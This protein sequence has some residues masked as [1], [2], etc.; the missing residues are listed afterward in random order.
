[1]LQ[2]WSEKYRPQKLSEVINQ[3]HAV[4]RIKAFVEEKNIPH[5]LFA[6]P[7]GVGKTTVALALAHDLYGKEWRTNT[8]ELNASV[9]PDTPIM[10][11]KNG[12][13]RRINFGQLAKE[14]FKYK[15]EKVVKTEDLEILSLEDN[16]KIKFIPVS[17]I[18]RHKVDKIAKIKFEGGF[19]KTSLNH[20]VIIINEGGELVSKRVEDI[21][22]NDLLI[23]FKDVLEGSKKSLNLIEYRPQIFTKLKENLIVNSKIK[24]IYLNIKMNKEIAWLLGLYLAEGCSVLQNNTRGQ[25]V[26][27]LSSEE[28]R[29]GAKIQGILNKN[30]GLIST[31]ETAPSGFDRNN[32][33]SIQIR[34]NNT[35]LARFFKDN[36]YEEECKK[37]AKF[38]RVPDFVYNWSIDNRLNFLKGYMGD[39]TGDWKD[40]VRFSSRSKE[41]LIDI[42][43]L[44][45]ISSLE[46]SCFEREARIIWKKPTSFYALTNL[47]PFEPFAKLFEYLGIP[48][49]KYFL[50]HQLYGKKSKRISKKLLKKFFV[51]ALKSKMTLNQE[52]E[53]LFNNCSKL[54]NSP[55]S[56]VRIKDIEISNCYD[57]VYDVSVPGIE[58]FWG[59]TV[60]ILLHNSDSR[61]IDIIRGQ[62]KNF[63]RTR[64]M[65]DVGYRLVVLD[66]AD[67]LTAEAQQAL[68]R[69]ME[70][71]TSVSRFILICNW[72]SRII[73][74]I[75]SRA[76]IFRFKPL[77]EADQKKYIDRIVKE[78]KL[79]I[80]KKAIDAII[81]LAEGDLRK[82]SNLLQAS[83]VLGKKITEDTIY[84][85]ASQARPDDVKKMVEF[86]LEGRFEDARKILQDMLLRQGLSGEDIIRE[87]HRQI[88]DLKIDEKDK[89]KLIE[90]CGEYEYRLSQG[91]SDTIQLEALLAQ[92][93]VF[94]KK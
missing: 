60:P 67:A 46:T 49:A 45:R 24:Q 75:Q 4:E 68:R 44:G 22:P 48:K 2:V 25:I 5:M 21:K 81:Y 91:S 76:A 59:G 50:R 54:L 41:N 17:N 3:K 34:A 16:Y 70:N 72:S 86:T 58:M 7:A 27:T 20:S 80:D 61:G 19:I 93:L 73:E 82:I 36:F 63:A 35:Q 38:K 28:R 71:F 14:Y 92:F 9:T 85:V 6:G 55:L 31:L 42:A 30:F 87:I 15:K 43:W 32:F 29:M 53:E 79:K 56:V 12:K 11:R 37:I 10:I 84:E 78:E 1:M 77:S 94:S 40:C 18:S 62:V 51:N 8:L 66:E 39:A 89:I 57:Y 47:L 23:T 26:F 65:S 88:Y 69:T 33:S 64:T 90:T 13:I 74:P 52:I 83:A